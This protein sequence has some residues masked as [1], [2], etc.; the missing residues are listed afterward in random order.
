MS[1]TPY[2]TQTG[3][4]INPDFFTYS[5][6]TKIFKPLIV[7]K[8]HPLSEFVQKKKVKPTDM[9]VV[10]E[11]PDNS[12]FAIKQADIGYHHVAQGITENGQPW[13]VMF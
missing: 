11:L 9:M 3:V 7:K 5:G 12:I 1:N 8:T 6:E 10:V 13:M 4:E 2:I